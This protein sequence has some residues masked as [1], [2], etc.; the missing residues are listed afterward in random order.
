LFNETEDILYE[1][2]ENIKP[3]TTL[4]KRHTRTHKPRV[5]IPDYL[6]REDI[7]HDIA[8]S[9]KVCP[10]DVTQLQPIDSDNHEQLDI[11]HAKIKVI[12]HKRLK[13]TCPCCDDYIVTAKKPK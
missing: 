12:R 5:G 7:V 11:I 1:E 9:E 10:H 8:E 2:K 3:K 4:I 6:P 13:H